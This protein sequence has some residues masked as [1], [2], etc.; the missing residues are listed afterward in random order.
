MTAPLCTLERRGSVAVITMDDGKV[1]AQNGAMMGALEAAFDEAEASDAA[2]VVLT[3]RPTIF[4]AGLDL[5]R[6]PALPRDEMLAFTD[7]YFAFMARAFTFPKPLVCAVGGHAIAGGSVLLMT[8]DRRLGARGDYRLGL[9]EVAI[10]IPLPPVVVALARAGLSRRAEDEALLHGSTFDPARGAEVGYFHAL[11]E[12]G[13]LLE[14]AVADAARLGNLPG[15][16]YRQTKALLRGV[17]MEAALASQDSATFVGTFL[18][19]TGG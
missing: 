14:V 16:A 7:R 10:G 13:D 17:P 19:A 6:L 15:R 8:G 1:N 3:G 9:T 18:D 4:S 12:P 11:V 5:K 2:A